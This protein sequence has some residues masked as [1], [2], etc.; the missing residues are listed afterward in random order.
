MQLA[1]AEVR[2]NPRAT[3]AM[4]KFAAI[5][6]KDAEKGVHKLLREEGLECIVQVD[7][8]EV[9]PGVTI[10]YI[11]LSSWVK[12]LLDSGNLSKFLVG[13]STLG[14]MKIVLK[15]WW[16]RFQALYPD[17]SYVAHAIHH[18]IP[19][20]S[21]IPFLSHADDG[22]SYKHLGIWILSS[23]GCL[24]RGTSKHVGSKRHTLPL[25]ENG[26]GTN[27]L[28]KTWT[29][30]FVFTTVLKTM[31]N[32]YP[33]LL[34]DLTTIYAE[35]AKNLLFEGVVSSNGQERI[36]LAHMGFKADLP[37]LQKVG[38]FERCWSHVPKQASSKNLLLDAATSAWVVGKVMILFLLKIFDQRQHGHLLC[39]WKPHG[40]MVRPPRFFKDYH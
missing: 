7:K 33:S 32:N 9:R 3:L 16:G 2:E 24:G 31:Y 23:A 22:R 25:S 4:R 14:K 34:D 10:P 40:R 5:R 36:Y 17:H 20:E 28:G 13:V 8:F 29:T 21:L 38:H 30:Q 39:V 35:D 12:H 27:F 37:M 11:K 15:E 26:M 6:L 19:F 1:Q 18:G